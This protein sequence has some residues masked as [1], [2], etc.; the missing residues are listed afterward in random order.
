LA[1]LTARMVAAAIERRTRSGSFE[2]APTCHYDFRTP[3]YATYDAIRPEKW[4]SCRGVGNS[5]GYNR[6]ETEEHMILPRIASKSGNL[7]L[8]VGPMADGTIPEMQRAPLLA[9]GSIPG[10]PPS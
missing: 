5:F 3:E 9:L 7:L 1:R 4:E 6:N 10:A 8:N 2:M